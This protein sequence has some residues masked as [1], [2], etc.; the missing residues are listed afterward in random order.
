MIFFT[1]S[2]EG[3]SSS[4]AFRKYFTA[5]HVGAGVSNHGLHPLPADLLVEEVGQDG[6]RLATLK[7][8]RTAAENSS[9][10]S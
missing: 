5:G 9:G 10:G 3:H 8:S 7:S 4:Q 6:S 2:N 1:V